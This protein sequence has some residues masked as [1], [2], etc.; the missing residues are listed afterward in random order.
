M[1]AELS[2]RKKLQPLEQ[3]RKADSENHGVVVASVW[4]AITY[5]KGEKMR[6]NSSFCLLG[7]AIILA[8]IIFYFLPGGIPT[9]K[10]APPGVSGKV[11]FVKLWNDGDICLPCHNKHI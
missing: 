7:L 9:E 4:L 11:K 5:K 6:L 2:P 10:P 3:A 1:S 8:L